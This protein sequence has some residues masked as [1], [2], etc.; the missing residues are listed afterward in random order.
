MMVGM[1]KELREGR[2]SKVVGIWHETVRKLAL[3][4]FPLVCLLLVTARDVIVTLFTE[5]YVASVP[6]FMVGVAA[7]FKQF[8][9]FEFVLL[10]GRVHAAHLPV[11]QTVGTKA[12]IEKRQNVAQQE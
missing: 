8:S 12:Y 1:A 10:P 3:V 7:I 5:T 6:V 4:F 2:E 11:T 9:R